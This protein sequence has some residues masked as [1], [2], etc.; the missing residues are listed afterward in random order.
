MRLIVRSG[1]PVNTDNRPGPARN[2]R[3][4]RNTSSSTSG[5]VRIGEQRGRDDRSSKPA[6]PSSR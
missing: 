6:S 2:R 5:L 4:A 1:T 3:R